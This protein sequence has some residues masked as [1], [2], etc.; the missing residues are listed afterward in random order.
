MKADLLPP[1]AALQ[2]FLDQSV[3]LWNQPGD[4]PAPHS[5]AALEL[6]GF[7]RSESIGT[8]Y[9]QATLAFE[10]AADYSMALVKT[11]TPPGQSIACWGCARSIV[12]S[13]ALAT[14][15]WDTKINARQRVQRSLVFRH[16]GL[17]QQLK[18]ARAS[19]G[20][21]DQKKAIARLNQVEYIAL[22]LG[23]AKVVDKKGRKDIAWEMVM[24]TVTEIV[25]EILKKE[26]TYRMLSA[27]VHG[28]HWALRSLAFTLTNENRDI[29]PGVK[30]GYLEKHLDYSAIIYLCIE[31]LNCLTSPVLMKFKLFGWDARPM[32][33]LIQRTQ[34]ELADLQQN[35]ASAGGSQVNG[36]GVD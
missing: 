6:A 34:K 18:L 9:S 27:I 28:H 30:G 8:A 29:F 32:A 33:I 15:L 21:L 17:V 26:E 7:A 3:V 24:P 10:S 25:T 11:L 12:E 35:Q 5:Q 22:E 14:W 36:G 31:T 4:Q 2:A 19:K 16:E 20:H 23:M 1:V 13:S